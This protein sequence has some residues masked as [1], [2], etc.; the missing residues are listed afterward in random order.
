MGNQYSSNGYCTVED[1]AKQNYILTDKN[2][3]PLYCFLNETQDEDKD[4]DSQSTGTLF[5]GTCKKDNF[6]KFL[7]NPALLNNKQTDEKFFLDEVAE[8]Q[9]IPCS[10]KHIIP[11]TQFG[12]ANSN[13]ENSLPKI[14]LPIPKSIIN[15]NNYDIASIN[16]DALAKNAIKEQVNPNG[17]LLDI[18]KASN[19]NLQKTLIREDARKIDPN[20][21]APAPASATGG[22]AV[23]PTEQEID[24]KLIGIVGSIAFVVLL[25]ILAVL[26]R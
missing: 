9:F 20:A 14:S 15:F 26:F 22:A 10:S 24:I 2:K 18:L 8:N 11:K 17:N 23:A 3:Q 13:S 4:K 6:K 5:K 16:V 12:Q 1:T 19:N 25:I 21:P 7:D